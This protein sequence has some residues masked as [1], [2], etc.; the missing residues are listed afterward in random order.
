[1]QSYEHYMNLRA[2]TMLAEYEH[3]LDLANDAN[4]AAPVACMV[5]ENDGETADPSAS[6]P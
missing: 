1:M 2:L 4:G 5:D 6:A 3:A